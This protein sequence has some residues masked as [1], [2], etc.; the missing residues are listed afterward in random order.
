MSGYN[1]GATRFCSLSSSSLPP[2]SGVCSMTSA[3][4]S[5]G[6]SFNSKLH[7]TAKSTR[8]NIHISKAGP[9]I[10][11]E[12]FDTTSKNPDRKECAEILQQIH[13]LGPDDAQYKFES[14]LDWFKRN[15]AA[16]K[17]KN[18]GTAP[19]LSA[20]SEIQ[21]PLHNPLYP[22]LSSFV[23]EQLTLELR[24]RAA[25]EAAIFAVSDDG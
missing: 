9:K 8:R 10:M 13:M 20:Q 7:N 12:Y 16:A 18:E 1:L 2:S 4:P 6:P 19:T 5:S 17:K 11:K 14:V 24:Q 21:G 25:R 23:I 22:S 3:G 15:C